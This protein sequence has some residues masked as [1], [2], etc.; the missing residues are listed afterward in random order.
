MLMHLSMASKA[1]GAV[2]EVDTVNC[3]NVMEH[4][5]LID[6]TYDFK[7]DGTIAYNLSP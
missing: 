2:T 1:Y 7:F 5:R 6:F 3:V 4:I